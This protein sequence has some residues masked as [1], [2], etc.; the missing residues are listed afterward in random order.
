MTGAPRS[1]PAAIALAPAERA[2]EPFAPASRSA[3][4]IVREVPAETVTVTALP[5]THRCRRC[6][7]R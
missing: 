2:L 4:A 1:R 6:R 3:A 7:S 5:A